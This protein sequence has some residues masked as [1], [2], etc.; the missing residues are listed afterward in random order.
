M[1]SNFPQ[2]FFDQMNLF[3]QNYKFL[4]LLTAIFVMIGYLSVLF[5]GKNNIIEVEVEKVIEMQTG[6]KIDLTP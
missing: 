6:L 5:L 1:N 2:E 3:W 4:I